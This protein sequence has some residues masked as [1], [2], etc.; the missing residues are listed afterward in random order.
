MENGIQWIIDIYEELGNGN[1]WDENDEAQMK[2]NV[3]FQRRHPGADVIPSLRSH[4]RGNGYKF[5]EDVPMPKTEERGID[6]FNAEEM[7]DA[8]PENQPEIPEKKEEEPKKPEKKK[9]GKAYKCDSCSREFNHHLAL[10][11]HKKKCKK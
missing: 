9:T 10:F 7:I 3:A 4:L 1:V 6:A 11:N 2:F 5:G 8:P